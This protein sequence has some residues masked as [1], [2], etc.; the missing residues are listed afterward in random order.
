[1]G[2]E[3]AFSQN[4]MA[5][6]LAGPFV[7]PLE[8]DDPDFTI[9]YGSLQSSPRD[10][11]ET[12]YIA[13]ASGEL[14]TIPAEPLGGTRIRQ[15]RRK[16]KAAVVFSLVLHAAAA[17]AFLATGDEP[18][19][20]EGADQAGVMLLGNAPEDQ[21]SAGDITEA[22]PEAAKVT[23]VTMLAPKPVE[24]VEAQPVA[25]TETAQPV[26][27]TK[28]EAAAAATQEP[29]RETPDRPTS[30]P[31]RVDPVPDEAAMA[32]AIN[33]LPEILTV[34]QAVE[35]DNSVQKPAEQSTATV[36][37]SAPERTAPVETLEK[38][39]AEAEPQPAPEEK[40]PQPAKPQPAKP[41]SA[42][43]KKAEPAKKPIKKAQKADAQKNAVKVPAKQTKSGSGGQN[44]ADARRGV[45]EGQTDGKTTSKSQGGKAG[46]GNASVSNY[47]GKV[48][49]K[50]RRALRGISSSARAKARNDVQVSFTVNANGGVGG[51][52]IARSSGS[53]ELDA[54]ALAVIRRAAPFPP[55]P[56]DAGRTSW[57][58]ALPLGL[59][60]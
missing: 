18:V 41:Q 54:A 55:I 7:L 40:R 3:P 32:T 23:L 17:M 57:A 30:V 22:P 2:F 58:F 53:P 60:R 20:I 14:T 26:E 47:P 44:E 8:P 24:T 19:L 28:A 43:T 1:M 56:A 9:P 25:A 10:A 59:A 4:T 51:I 5:W 48:V 21:S 33:P 27:T 15:P 34:D 49:A 16:W 46:I 37:A 31:D 42:K 13:D 50:L 39:T 6:P 38:V 36:E 12:S 45:A 52:R 35:D 11:P 29:V